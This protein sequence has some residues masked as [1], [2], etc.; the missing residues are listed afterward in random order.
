VLKQRIITACILASTVVFGIFLLPLTGVAIFVAVIMLI[1]AWEWGPFLGIR[2]I[3]G[4]FS[5]LVAV[6]ALLAVIW[7]GFFDRA[8]IVIMPLTVVVWIAAFIW[9]K[10]YPNKGLWNNKIVGLSLCLVLLSTTWWSLLQLK[11]MPMGN[12]WLLLVLLVVWAADIGAY[13]A[14]KSFGKRKLAPNVSPGKTVEGF[15]GGVV[16]ASITAL[17]FSVVQELSTNQTLYLLVLGA[18]I[19][20]VSVLGD[21]LESMMKRNADLKDSGS[22]L[23]GHGGILDRIDSLLA[24]APLF[25]IG[26]Q[27]LPVT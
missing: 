16:A 7:F 8:M 17:V 1:G 20:M 27:W 22:L 11:L 6:A 23:P 9:V 10:T 21:L 13:I 2:N 4:K 5:L 15:V 12:S 14:G 26:L 3:A 18:L 24:A 25:L 19:S